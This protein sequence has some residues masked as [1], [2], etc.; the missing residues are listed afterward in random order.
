LPFDIAEAT[1]LL[2]PSKCSLISTEDLIAHHAQQLLKWPEDLH[3]MADHVLKARK[4]S[5]AQFVSRFA[6][7]I[8]DYDLLVGPLMLLWNSPC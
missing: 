7:T 5:V 4:L 6:S 2:P 8:V 1:Y 3:D